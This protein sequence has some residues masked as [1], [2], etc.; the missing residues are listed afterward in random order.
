MWHRLMTLAGASAALLVACQYV[1]GLHEPE[2]ALRPPPP[3]DGGPDAPDL[4]AHALPPR[5]PEKDDDPKTVEPPF[6]LAV[7]HVDV[8]NDGGTRPGLDLDGVCT[9]FEGKTAFGG[10]GSCKP[11][12]AAGTP[13]DGDGG[14]DNAFGGVLKP[15]ASIADINER[16]AVNKYIELGRSGVLLQISGYNGKANDKELS[17]AMVVAKG[18]LSDIGCDGGTRGRQPSEEGGVTYS[19]VWDGCD[20]WAADD[21]AV[22]RDVVNRQVIGLAVAPGYVV[23]GY[24]VV[25]NDT[26]AGGRSSLPFVFGGKLVPVLVPAFVGKLVRDEGDGGGPRFRL[27]DVL[28]TGRMSVTTALGIVGLFKV[29]GDE[30]KRFCE[31]PA[32]FDVARRNICNAA[33]TMTNRSL[34]NLPDS[35]CDALSL[36]LHM[37][38]R[39][40]T[41]DVYGNDGGAL[42]GQGCE[43]A[44]P[45]R[46]ADELCRDL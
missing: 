42:I 14:V 31:S 3:L 8:T 21:S 41:V 17:V 19:P 32:F 10:A 27:E 6:W 23:D 7:D 13:C 44:G 37:S 29:P 22:L 2:G 25:A 30:A 40:A 4:C 43:D 39:P 15:F 36:S 24:L 9:C 20:Q 11:R 16:I 1:I 26:A 5:P 28:V 34:D 33:D 38:A 35:V 46:P 18:L 12:A 45:I